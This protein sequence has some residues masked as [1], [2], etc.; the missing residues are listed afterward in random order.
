MRRNT[1]LG[2]FTAIGLIS[3]DASSAISDRVSI[4]NIADGTLIYSYS[5]SANKYISSDYAYKLKGKW[6]ENANWDIK[7]LNNGSL[8]FKNVYS[9]LCLQYYGD[10]WQVI[11]NTC[12]ENNKEQHITPILSST[13]AVKLKFNSKDVCLYNYAGDQHFYVYSDRCGNDKKFLW[14]LVPRLNDSNN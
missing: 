1:I 11:E 12:N 14:S 4:Y 7:Y 8:Q 5:S 10:R 13:G 6:N 2:L 9:K 3:F